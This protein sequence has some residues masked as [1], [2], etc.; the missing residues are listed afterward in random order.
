MTL[1]SGFFVRHSLKFSTYFLS[2]SGGYLALYINSL[3]HV[4]MYSYYLTSALFS[5]RRV[6]NKFKPLITVIQIT[7]F[8]IVLVQ[9]LVHKVLMGCQYP[10][11][12]TLYYSFGFGAFTILFLDFYRKTY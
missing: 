3:V 5:G 6:L 1:V 7:Q 11:F 8:V 10:I 12:F 4:I 9:L 2:E